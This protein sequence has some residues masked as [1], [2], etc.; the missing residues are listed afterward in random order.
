MNSDEI[1]AIKA[2]MEGINNKNRLITYIMPATTCPHCGTEN[3]ENETTASAMLFLRN[4]L[5]A[6]VNTSI[7]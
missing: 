4:Q 2:Y 5:A 7:S 1:N 3:P 6:L